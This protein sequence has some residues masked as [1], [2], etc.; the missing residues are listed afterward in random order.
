VID[1][2]T[3]KVVNVFKA[4]RQIMALASSKD[5]KRLYAFSIGQD[6]YVLDP[7]RG[8]LLDTIPLTNRNITGIGRT[9][10]LP[11]WSPYQENDYLVSFAV[12]ISDTL[13][14]Q[15]TLGIAS[16]DLTQPDP[17]LQTVELQPYTA[18]NYTLGGFLSPK[19][20]KVYFSYNSLWKVDPATRRVEKTGVVENTYFSP[21]LHPEG[22]KIYCGGNWHNIAV[23]DAETL[24][25]ITKVELGNTQA[26]GSLRFVQR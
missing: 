6:I 23:F 16:L 9:D 5:G 25:P 12:V 13:T 1:L 4:P 21:F 3:N 15:T 20:H 7:E 24:D 8:T 17:E 10:G 22:K 11:I 19:N 14:N 26:G 18:E 2:D